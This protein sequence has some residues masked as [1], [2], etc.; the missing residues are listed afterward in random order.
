M[1]F[2]D[3]Y[4]R[5]NLPVVPFDCG[6]LC[7]PHNPNL[8]PFCCD[9]CNAV[10]SVY[11]QEWDYLVGYTDLW[12]LWR[13]DECIGSTEDPSIMMAETPDRMHLVA[14]LG[15]D[16]CQRNYRSLSCR[17]FP[18]FPYIT[19]DN[20]FI[21]LAYNWSFEETCWVISHLN[22]VSDDFR[23][24]FVQFYDQFFQN[25]PGEIKTYAE[26][27]FQMRSDFMAQKR[28]IPL[29]HRDGG[30]YLLRPIN[31]RLR[32]VEPDRLPRLGVYQ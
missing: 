14:C 30:Y 6:E 29:L 9:I 25:N 16:H 24:A 3:L 1:D 32:A 22:Q 13:G 17:Q 19:P 15:P 20:N 4:N 7:A 26:R 28:S 8:K 18:F 5:F 2:P 27:S 23:V 12:H 10:P 11:H 31:Q 21:G